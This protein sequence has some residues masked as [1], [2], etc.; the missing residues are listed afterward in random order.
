LAR[1]GALQI[2]GTPLD[3]SK[4]DVDSFSVGGITDH[5]TPWEAVYRSSL[6]LGG[7]R[8]FVLANSGHVQSIINP[9]DSNPKAHFQESDCEESDPRTWFA[10]AEQRPGSWWPEWL[11]WIQARSGPLQAARTVLGSERY[12]EL[13]AAPG[14]YVVDE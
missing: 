13:D 8:R 7:K 4:V 3:L 6:L 14:R 10:Q 1:R 11:S 2:C 12:P 9:P 5:I